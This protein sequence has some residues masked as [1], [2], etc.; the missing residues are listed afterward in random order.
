LQ[1]VTITSWQVER[2]NKWLKKQ[3]LSLQD[4]IE[5]GQQEI[6]TLE[7]TLNEGKVTI[8]HNLEKITKSDT[9]TKIEEV[10]A[11]LVGTVL[12]ESELKEQIKEAK[13]WAQVVNEPSTKQKEAIQKQARRQIR[14]EKKYKKRL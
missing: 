14:E 8:E 6:I 10:Q 3:V 5:R 4:D 1:E 11:T 2:E 13:S 9:T 12:R 7:Q